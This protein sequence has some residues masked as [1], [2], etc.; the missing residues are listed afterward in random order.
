MRPA[1]RDGSSPPI[2]IE[3]T[4]KG[5]V[6]AI[7]FAYKSGPMRIINNGYTAARVNYPPGNG[8]FLIVGDARYELTQFHLHHHPSEEDVH[9]RPFA[10]AA[11]LMHASKDG[12]VAGVTVLLKVGTANATVQRLWDHVPARAGAEHEIAGVEIDPSGLLPRE[13]GYYMYAG[14]QAAQPCTEGVTWL[15]L[16]TPA[17]IPLTAIEA[18][19]KLYP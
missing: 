16:K 15:V 4:T 3:R 17:E 19:G 11:H 6:P 7:R 13:L 1:A 10:M 5:A 2:D 9:G 8:H 18:F 14:S 12:K